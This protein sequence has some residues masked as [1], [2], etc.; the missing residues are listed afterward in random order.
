MLFAVIRCYSLLFALVIIFFISTNINAQKQKRCGSDFDI[1][2]IKQNDPIRYQEILRIEKQTQ[3]YVNKMKNTA[4]RLIDENGTI[5]I[6]VVIHVIHKNEP[7]G[8]GTNISDAQIQSQIDVLNED[9][10]RLNSDQSNTRSE[11]LPKAGV[12]NFQFRLACFDPNGN[13]TSGIIRSI[14]PSFSTNP[15]TE[16]LYNRETNNAKFTNL[17]GQDAWATDRYLNIWVVP[18]LTIFV[19]TLT[20]NGSPI[21]GYAQFPDDFLLKASTDGVVVYYKAFG[22]GYANLNPQYNMGRTATHE[23]AHWLNLLHV[24]EDGC[25]GTD[26]CDD[27]PTQAVGNFGCVTFPHITCNNG[28][29]GDMFQNYMDVSDDG[30]MNLFTKDQVLRMRAVFQ[31]GGV[32]RNF[33]DNYFKLV[34]GNT[35]CTLGL[36]QLITPFCEANGNITWN[37]TGPATSAPAYG[38]NKLRHVTPQSGANGTAVLSASWNNFVSD[39]TI[40]YGFGNE[41][42]LYSYSGNTFA[43]TPIYSGGYYPAKSGSFGKVSFSGATGTAQ[44]WRVVSQTGSAYFY[45]SGNNFNVSAYP[46]NS[47]IT[48]KADVNTACGLRTIQYTFYYSPYGY[49]GGGYS[50]RLSP[51]PASNSIT[52]QAT[53]TNPDPNARVG[54]SPE[55][56]VQIYNRFS[57]LLKTVKCPKGTTEIQV[58]VNGLPSNQLYTARIVSGVDIQNISFFKE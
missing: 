25:T 54:D 50:Y 58:D 43:N 37:I 34:L 24:F 56:D 42:S 30:C 7:L 55:Y 17:G 13:A 26:F 21:L 53:N 20:N 3:D 28:P 4:A 29:L 19:P 47:N 18:T 57:Q 27:T 22:R 38:S 45:G 40:L 9:F 44:N 2:S 36:Y 31:T 16:T 14:R 48:V 15:P 8:V 11:W 5:T 10:N 35:T 1:N 51:N 46:P 23:V 12:P 32:R 39:F 49:G 33:I 41:G 6:P 52:I